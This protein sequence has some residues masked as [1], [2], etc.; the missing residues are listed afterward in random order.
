MMLV[1]R[2]SKVDNKIVWNI[3]EKTG[4][5]FNTVRNL[6]VCGWTYK[7]GIDNIPVWISPLARLNELKKPENL[8]VGPS[9][10]SRKSKE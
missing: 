3:S 8:P 10:I 5:H 6:L 7:E 1:V 2:E 9:G 4:L